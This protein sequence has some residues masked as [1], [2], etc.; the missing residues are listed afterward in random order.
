MTGVKSLTGEKMSDILNETN[1][2]ILKISDSAEHSSIARLAHALSVP[3][4]LKILQCILN[5]SMSL[6]QIQQELHLPMTSISRHIDVLAKAGLIYITYVPGIKGHVKFCSQSTMGFA[7]SLAPQAPVQTNEAQTVEMPVGMFTSCHVSAPCGMLSAESSL[8]P[9]DMPDIF[10]LPERSKAELIWFDKG[11]ICYHFPTYPL[12]HHKCEEITF[13]FE[14]CSETMYFN[15]RW[16]SDITLYINDLEILTFTSPG[17]FGGRKGKYTPEFWPITSTQYG[18]LKTLTI[19]KN[20]VYFDD[21]F[22]SSE[23]KFSDLDLYDGKEAIKFKIGIKEGS[24]HKGGINL[25]GKNFG[26][27]PQA[28]KMSVK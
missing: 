24:I 23:I 3:E 18:Q 27:Y 26:D 19:N 28:I 21:I 10:F 17:D 20:G 15:P 13:S 14:I 16:P 12:K 25:F 22:R 7:V 6:S 11:F 9:M 8:G 4:R 1:L 2:T 5:K